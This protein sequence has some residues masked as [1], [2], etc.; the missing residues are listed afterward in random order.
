MTSSN[1]AGP[2]STILRPIVVQEIVGD[3]TSSQGIAIAICIIALW[4]ASLGFLLSIHLAEFPVWLIPLAVLWQAF[5]YTGLFIT[6]HDAMHGS[7]FPRNPKVNAFVGKLT[8]F[9]YGFFSYRKLLQKHWLHHKYPATE[10]DPDFHNGINARPIAWYLHFMKGYWDWRQW[11]GLSVIYNVAR[12][13]LH[14]SEINLMMFWA[15]PPLLSSVQLFYFGTFLTHKEPE[16]GYTHPDCATTNPLP[17]FWSFITCY[18]FGYHEEHHAYPHV[19][20]W[21]L[22]AIYKQRP[23]STSPFRK[24]S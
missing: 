19:S 4:V 22:P 10:L 5:L 24:R 9:A 17:I 11:L 12:F 3:K 2:H 23:R 1:Y 16:T 6:A 21:Q 13:G 15:I 7:V 14:I 18:H 8:V 20:W